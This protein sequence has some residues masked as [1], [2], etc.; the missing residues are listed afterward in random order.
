MFRSTLIIISDHALVSFSMTTRTG[1]PPKK[2][3]RFNTSL[4]DDQ[5]Y[6]KYFEIDWEIF[7]EI[8]GQACVLQE[9]AITVMQGKIISN[10]SYKQKN[11]CSQ[12]LELEQKTQSLEAVH[13]AY[14][15]EHILGNIRKLKLEL[16]GLIHKENSVSTANTLNTALYPVDFQLTN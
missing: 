13:A 1:T 2:C 14:Q 3:W 5:D 16:N 7:L 15:E 4:L 9:T 12:E 11:E 10:S 6:I 8:N